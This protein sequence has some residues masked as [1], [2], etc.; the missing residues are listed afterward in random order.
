MSSLYF[1]MKKYN[2]YVYFAPIEW[3]KYY[4]QGRNKIGTI[5]L[6]KLI[7]YL[8]P[9]VMQKDVY[10]NLQKIFTVHLFHRTNRSL[11]ISKYTYN[12]MIEICQVLRDTPFHIKLHP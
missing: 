12:E 3:K 7:N 5:A 6:N 10:D 11:M 9:P 2:L 1:I 4:K 8:N